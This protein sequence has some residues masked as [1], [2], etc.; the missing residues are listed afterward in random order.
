MNNIQYS[1]ENMLIIKLL[2]NTDNTN[3]TNYIIIEV[4]VY[5]TYPRLGGKR[6]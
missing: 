2:L 5:F 4:Y 6:F 3:Y 1:L